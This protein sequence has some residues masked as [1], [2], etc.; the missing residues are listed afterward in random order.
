[1]KYNLVKEPDIVF[2]LDDGLQVAVEVEATKKSGNQLQPKLAVLKKY[3]SWFF[4][5]TKCE[6]LQHYRQYGFTFT[7][8][9]MRK[10]IASYFGANLTLDSK[11]EAE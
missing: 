4:V 5:V 3:N 10:V 11:T 6:N 8:T 2:T 9:R 1:M 7:R